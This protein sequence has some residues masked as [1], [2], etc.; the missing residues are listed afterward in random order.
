MGRSGGLI[1][2]GGE[3]A[4]NASMAF[5]VNCNGSIV[6]VAR[7]EVWRNMPTNYQRGIAIERKAMKLLAGLGYHSITR[8]PGSKG[9]VDV[10]ASHDEFGDLAV[11][12]KSSKRS[13][14]EKERS[15]YIEELRCADLPPQYA[16]ELWIC[17]RRG[18][19][20]PVEWSRWTVDADGARPIGGEQ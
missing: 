10:T 3:A 5:G 14:G 19:G 17:R 9:L 7:E 8:A 2:L 15:R 18:R 12:V 4:Q 13:I 1:R 11:S 16:R 20:R 6:K